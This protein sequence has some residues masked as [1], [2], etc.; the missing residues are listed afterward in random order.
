MVEIIDAIDYNGG[1]T[2]NNQTDEL[3]QVMTPAEVSEEFNVSQSTVRNT[4]HQG[5]ID[6]RKSGAATLLRRR[7]VIDR[8]GHRRK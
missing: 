5:R 7:D 6:Y 3:K 1:M 8:W 4:I 2:N